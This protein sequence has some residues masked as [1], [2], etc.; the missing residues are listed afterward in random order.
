MNNAIDQ[1]QQLSNVGC[2]A[3]VI[4]KGDFSHAFFRSLLSH[5]NV[6]DAV[7]LSLVSKGLHSV[8]TMRN[9]F[10]GPHPI[11]SGQSQSIMESYFFEK[12][13][14]KID[15]DVRAAKRSASRKMRKLLPIRDDAEFLVERQALR[16]RFRNVLS[17]VAEMRIQKSILGENQ[18][19]TKGQRTA[20]TKRLRAE[21]SRANEEVIR[22]E[23]D[24]MNIM[25]RLGDVRRV[26][27]RHYLNRS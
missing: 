11:L 4:D 27:L 6:R 3:S 25:I 8:M 5:L 15:Q 10:E 24:T 16:N 14:P 13:Q 7:S 23:A 20:E 26:D 1:N 22:L 19:L 21:L 17:S 2:L 12:H 9:P 18:Y